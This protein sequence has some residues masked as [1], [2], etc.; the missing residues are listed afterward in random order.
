VLSREVGLHH[1]Q[2]K[3]NCLDLINKV[4]HDVPLKRSPKSLLRDHYTDLLPSLFKFGI[5]RGPGKL[6]IIELGVK[7][8]IASP[9]IKVNQPVP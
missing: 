1:R 2:I 9:D 3:V 8:Q 5:G 6:D 4:L 7:W